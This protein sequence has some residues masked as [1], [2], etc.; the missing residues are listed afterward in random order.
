MTGIAVYAPPN[1]RLPATNP[2]ARRWGGSGTGQIPRA[3]DT[4]DGNPLYT[5]YNANPTYCR[6]KRSPAKT[7][8]QRNKPHTVSCF[9][10]DVP[11]DSQ[12]RVQGGQQRGEKE[13]RIDLFGFVRDEGMLS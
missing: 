11:V 7:H 5:T 8:H 2:R 4:G 13:N 10:G 3:K 12:S 9:Y 6:T 1:E